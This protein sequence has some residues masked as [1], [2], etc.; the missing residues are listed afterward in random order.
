MSDDTTVT[1]SDEPAATPIDVRA[2][3]PASA[4]VPAP[5]RPGKGRRATG[6]L[7][8][9]VG[10]VGVVVCLALIVGVLLGRGWA[11]DTVNDVAGSLDAAIAR[12]DP[13]LATATG[14]IDALAGRAGEVATAAEA[15][16]G[17]PNATPQALQGVLD[18]LGAV[19]AG[20]LELRG[21]YGGAREQVVSA[22]DRLALIDRFVPGISV[23][24]AP[25]DA[26]ASLDGSIRALDGRVMAL[27]E[28][29]AAVQAIDA[30]ASAIAGSHAAP[31]AVPKLR[32]VSRPSKKRGSSD[33]IECASHS[34]TRGWR[35]RSRAISPASASW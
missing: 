27:I 31:S 23:P 33:A 6:I 14:S 4:P 1:P 16:A 26:L 11:T 12:V 34:A 19:S 29:G 5:A 20:Y 22:L 17:D 25:I 10:I 15:I 7:G 3:G 13:V 35:P 8:Q 9:V 28:A 2:P 18:R 32:S 24:Q 30:T 21:T